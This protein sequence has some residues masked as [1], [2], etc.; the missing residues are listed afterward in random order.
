VIQKSVET[1]NRGQKAVLGSDSNGISGTRTWTKTPQPDRE[2]PGATGISGMP[3]KIDSRQ[4]AKSIP[5]VE[6]DAS[7]C[8]TDSTALPRA[9]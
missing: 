9:S 2:Q 4:G 7:P 5:P 1:E 6:I 3:G 8:Q